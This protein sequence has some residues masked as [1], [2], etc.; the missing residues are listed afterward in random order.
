MSDCY[1][2]VIS[3]LLLRSLLLPLPY[4]LR[5]RVSRGE[6]SSF[7][8]DTIVGIYC[9]FSKKCAFRIE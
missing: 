1:T 3:V 6:S 7:Y 9:F 5:M 8:S 2:G 4:Q